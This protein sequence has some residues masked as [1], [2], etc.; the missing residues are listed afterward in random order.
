MFSIT[1][2]FSAATKSQ[3]EAQLSIL[4]SFASKAVD[5]AEKVIALNLSTTKATVETSSSAAKHLFEAKSPQ[6]FFSLG[7]AQQPG[8]ESLFAYGRQLFSIASS[9][10]AELIKTAQEQ[11]KDASALVAKKAPTLSA[12]PALKAPAAAVVAPVAVEPANEA[13]ATP[14]AKAPIKPKAEAKP[15]HKAEAEPVVAAPVEVKPVEAKPVE[16][17]KPAVTLVTEDKAAAPAKVKVEAKAETKVEAKADAKAAPAK[18][19]D[20]V[21]GNGKGKK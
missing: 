19:L 17:A 16:A 11:I 18:Q 5:S 12:V 2:Q 9:A 8:F 1:E 13:L 21:S 10:Q 20:V 3:L 6:E 14:V 15:A 7:G 4:N